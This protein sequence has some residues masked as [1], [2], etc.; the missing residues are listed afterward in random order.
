VTFAPGDLS[1]SDN[2]AVFEIA[3]AKQVFAEVATLSTWPDGSAQIVEVAF[4]VEPSAGLRWFWAVYGPSVRRTAEAPATRPDE[5]VQAVE[6]DPPLEINDT[7]LGTM[8]VRVEPH[9]DLYYWGY[10]VPITG[11]L[12]WL[13]WRKFRL[14]HA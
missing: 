4:P 8:L 14:N 2:V 11:V 3:A 12:G 7:T 10:L 13:T 1:S 5:D 6:G 9:A